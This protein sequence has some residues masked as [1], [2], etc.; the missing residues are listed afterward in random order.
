MYR[1]K[2]ALVGKSKSRNNKIKTKLKNDD[3]VIVISGKAKGQ[4]GKIFKI[5]FNKARIFIR[6]VN[7]IKKTKKKSSEE[8]TGGI[9]EIEGSIHISNVMILD[10]EGNK[11]RIKYSF[12][13]G[14]KIRISSKKEALS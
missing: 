6:G 4:K 9:L 2:K 3:E 10:K 8:D 14:K 13:D 1:N 5:D 12:K 7:L 11:T